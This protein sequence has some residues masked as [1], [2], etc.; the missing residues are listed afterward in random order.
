LQKKCAACVH[1]DLGPDGEP[2][3]PGPSP[4]E[5]IAPS[6]L[7]QLVALWLSIGPDLQ[8][9]VAAFPKLPDAVKAGIVAMVR[10]ASGGRR[11]A[12]TEREDGS[13]CG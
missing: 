7:R 2:L 13:D 9:A 6:G 10:A 12:S 8:E 4:E 1:T 11:A 5:C 3:L